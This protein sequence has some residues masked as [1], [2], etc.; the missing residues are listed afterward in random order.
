MATRQRQSVL[1]SVLTKEVETRPMPVA[2]ASTVTPRVKI[3]RARR[4]HR[5]DGFWAMKL[6]GGSGRDAVR[7]AGGFAPGPTEYF[8]RDEAGEAMS[9]MAQASAAR[10]LR[11]TMPRGRNWMKRM[12]KRIM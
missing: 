9:A 8:R 10:P 7:R 5:T 12:M 3:A 2:S 1:T 6:R 11:A 4:N